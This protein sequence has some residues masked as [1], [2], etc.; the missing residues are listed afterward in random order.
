MGDQ[1]VRKNCFCTDS[2]EEICTWSDVDPFFHTLTSL[3]SKHHRPHRRTF[4]WMLLL[5]KAYCRQQLRGYGDQ[6]ANFIRAPCAYPRWIFTCPLL[7]T[8]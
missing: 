5:L 2:H 8:L 3:K 4:P 6:L 1:G 7:G